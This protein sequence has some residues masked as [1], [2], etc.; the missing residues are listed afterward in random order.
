VTE[1]SQPDPSTPVGS[2]PDDWRCYRHPDREGGVRCQRCERAICPDCMV[3]ASVGFQC[4]SC[5]RSGPPGPRPFRT[6]RKDP[7]VTWAIIAACVL[8]FLPSLAGGA[9]VA[10]R[11]DLDVAGDLAL[12]APAVASGEWWRL[13]TA[14]FVHYGLLHIGFNM[15]VLLQLGTLLEPAVGRVRFA[16]LYVTALL[17]GSCGALLLD[18]GALTAGASGAVFGLMAAAVLGLWRRG[19]DPLRSGLG[20]LLAVNLLLT[21]VIP[22]ISVGGH[23]GGLA[24]GAA[25]GGALFVPEGTAR[26]RA[27]G[28]A[29]VV[30]LGIALFLT[31]LWLAANPVT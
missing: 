16:A 14:G 13:F 2:S 1:P 19:M 6:L 29:A 18:P 5:V 25:A 27:L 10:G 28:T 9:A 8:V 3:Q 22:G 24:A 7:Y 17:G 23:L 11:G 26:D 21:F 12:N 4:P 15:F 31:G 20:G 30:A